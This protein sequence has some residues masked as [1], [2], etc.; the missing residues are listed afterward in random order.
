MSSTS[1]SST[2]SSSG[3]TTASQ[4]T[5]GQGL[6]SSLGLGSGLNVS[7]IIAAEVGMTEAP[8]TT[9]QAQQGNLTAQVSAVGQLKSLAAT[10]QDAVKTLATPSA[11]NSMSASST[12]SAV[13]GVVTGTPAATSFSVQ[14][15]QL[16]Q[17][18]ET[19]TSAITS[20]STIGSSGTMTLQLGTWST[21]NGSSSF[22]A[23][24]SA[25]TSI[26]ISSSD[27]LSSIASKINSANA[28]V[29]A[30]VLS[31]STGDRLLIQ[32]KSTG[33]AQGF[34][35]ETTDSS[36]NTGSASAL[37]SLAFDPSAGSFGMA[38]NSYQSAQDTKA[39]VNNIGVS[40][41]NDTISGVVSGLN[42]QVSQVTSS[43][44]QVT[45]SANTSAAVSNVQSF[46]AD[47]NALNDQ[48][49][50][51]VDFNTS[52]NT[53]GILEGDP[54][55]EN[56][57]NELQSLVLSTTS[58]GG[59]YKYLSDVGIT[60]GTNGDLTVNTSQLTNA[61]NTDP[62]D[63]QNLFAA[64]A[65]NLS[66]SGASTGIAVQL[67]NYT[68]TLMAYGSGTFDSET[69]NFQSL[70]TQNSSQQA[71]ITANGKALQAQLTAQY[72]YLDTEQ[73]QTTAM[74]NYFTQEAALWNNSSSSS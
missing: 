11:W 27:T 20:G 2:T 1:I 40:S 71:Q 55:T 25:A 45:V 64:G 59:A 47:Y 9:L 33:A 26:S 21:S 70:L 15:Q 65:S 36:G 60:V 14:V 13:T 74:S 4:A 58:Q 62:S 10:L 41:S 67:E 7:A 46:V 63:V 51:D 34:K 35:I 61:L 3:G 52:S 66:A 12:S 23:G 24:S 22:T 16:A 49:S 42:L 56:M 43:P 17:S 39:T 31:D 54:T 6:I 57:Q 38:A 29:T 28:G 30:T 69:A 37:S 48:L 19:A 18:Q 73:S 68:N 50:T 72:S 44:V 8:L 5:T 53:A 32:S